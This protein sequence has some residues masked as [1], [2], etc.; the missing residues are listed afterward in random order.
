MKY[1]L[2]HDQEPIIKSGRIVK[3]KFDTLWEEF[4]KYAKANK[5]S[6]L[7]DKHNYNKHIK[8]IF[9]SQSVKQLNSLDFEKF[10]QDLY[11]KGLS[12][13]TVKHQLVLIRTIFNYAIKH[14]LVKNFKNPLANS[15][16]KMPEINN[17]RQAYLTKQQAKDLLDIL[18]ST[19]KLTYHLTIL[20]LFAGAKF[21]EITGAA[22]QKNKQKTGAPL[23]WSDVN[24]NNSTIFFKKGKKGNER[25]IAIN[26]TLLETLHELYKVKVSDNVI[27]N[28]AGGIILRMPKYFMEALEVIIPGNKSRETKY[29]ITAHSLRHTHASWLAEVGLDLFQIKDQLGHRNIEMTMRYIHLIPN[30]R[31]KITKSLKL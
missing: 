10:K 19:H 14:E 15:K 29:K 31:H 23:K 27:T 3:I 24:F 28:S 12:A 16:V 2:Q 7:E 17:N 9:A 5:K 1:K 18:K 26:E 13:Q 8:P 20:L 21:S 22:S 30:I 6:W 11:S 4:L 25:H